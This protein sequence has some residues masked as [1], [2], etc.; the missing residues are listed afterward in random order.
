MCAQCSG[1]KL[2]SGNSWRDLS[3]VRSNYSDR[4][5]LVIRTINVVIVSGRRKEPEGNV[6]YSEFIRLVGRLRSW[7]GSY[8]TDTGRGRLSYC[9]HCYISLIARAMESDC[10]TDYNCPASC[11]SRFPDLQGEGRTV[12]TINLSTMGGPGLLAVLSQCQMTRFETSCICQQVVSPPHAVS[13]HVHAGLSVKPTAMARAVFCC[14]LIF[15]NVISSCPSP[16]SFDEWSQSPLEAFCFR[17]S[18]WIHSAQHRAYTLVE[19]LFSNLVKN[20]CLSPL[21]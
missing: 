17:A 5:L 14:T 2:A 10:V 11:T 13:V 15:R 1:E 12:Y 9:L 6:G 3:G 20:F 16:T 7:P 18:I 4:I 19:I 21:L 8:I